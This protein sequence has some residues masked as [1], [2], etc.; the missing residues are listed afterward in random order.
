MM[1][2]TKLPL[3]K[4]LQELRLQ[5][6]LTQKEVVWELKQRFGITAR[7]SY[8]S[9][10]ESG[11][12]DAPSLPLLAALAQ[13]LETSTDYLLG[14]TDN[15]LPVREIEEEGQAGGKEGRLSQILARLPREKQ[16]ELLSV[17]EAFIYR[18]MIDLLLNEVEEIGGK[19]ALNEVLDRLEASLPGSARRLRPLCPK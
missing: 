1:T 15:P 7:Q 5:Q 18:N 12:K 8:L 16:D 11:A 19:A 2:N 17:A 4:R 10:L 9:Q 3:A 14:L 6:G 13:V